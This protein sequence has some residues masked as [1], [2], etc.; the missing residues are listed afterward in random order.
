MGGCGLGNCLHEYMNGVAIAVALNRTLITKG[1]SYF[2]PYFGKPE[3]PVCPTKKNCGAALVGQSCPH[4]TPEL[5]L[6]LWP[7]W[8]DAAKRL[9]CHDLEGPGGQSGEV[10][11][12]EAGEG[13]GPVAR[14][15][16]R[17]TASLSHELPVLVYAV[18]RATSMVAPYLALNDALDEG[19]RRRASILFKPGVNTF[20]L[21]H[22][23]L[24][25]E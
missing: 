24:F 7:G 20:G 4:T 21:L 11:G 2:A 19:M 17:S 10:T 8:G 14:S 9:Y 3:Y 16:A 18:E 5:M 1:S 15:T 6:D 13:G 23:S 22:A 12:R 25:G